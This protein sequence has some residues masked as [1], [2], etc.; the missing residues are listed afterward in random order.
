MRRGA[1]IVLLVVLSI[2]LLGSLSFVGQ[3]HPIPAVQALPIPDGKLIFVDDDFTDDP[4]NHKWNTITEALDDATHGDIIFVFEGIYQENIFVSHSIQLLG[5]NKDT[6]VIDGMGALYAVNILANNVIMRNFSVTNG[7]EAGIFVSNGYH[8]VTIEK[9]KISGDQIPR[10]YGIEIIANDITIE[11]CTITNVHTGIYLKG[12]RNI[13]SE[14][15]I[16][17]GTTQVDWG[18]IVDESDNCTINELI[19]SDIENKSIVIQNSENITI[20]NSDITNSFTGIWIRMSYDTVVENNQIHD[21]NVGIRLDDAAKNNI[22]NCNIFDNFGCGV[23]SEN[24]Y[25]NIIHHNNFISNGINGYD[26]GLNL[27]NTSIGNYWDDYTGSDS[28]SDGIGDSPY[29][30]G[31]MDYRP[32]VNV[33]SIPPSY[34]W[35][36]DDFSSSTPGWQHDQFDSIQAAV[37]NVTSGGHIYVY[38]GLYF[39]EIVIGKPISIIGQNDSQV[40]A[41]GDAIQILTSDVLIEGLSIQAFENG[42]KILDANN[43]SIT[44]CNIGYDALLLGVLPP[45]AIF[46]VY[47]VNSFDCSIINCTITDS[48]KGIYLFNTSYSTLHQNYIHNNSYFGI[49][50]SHTSSNN[51]ISDCHI[52]NNE[53]FGIYI[54]NQ[55]DDNRIWHNNLIG[56][57]SYDAA[58]NIWGSYR[59]WAV[60]N[61]WSGYTDNDSN[62]DGMGD[63]PINIEGGA[64]ESYP[65][66]NPITSPPQFV[67]VNKI[68]DETFPGWNIDHFVAINDSLQNVTPNGGCYIFP[69]V[70]TEQIRINQPV[71][72]AGDLADEVIVDG[73][74]KTA[75]SLE[76]DDVVVKNL[77]VVNCWNG[78]G[79]HIISNNS[80]IFNLIIK[81]N[82]DGIVIEGNNISVREAKITNNSYSG[83]TANTAEM[84]NVSSNDFLFNNQGVI[85]S[86]VGKSSFTYNRIMNNSIN[87]LLMKSSSI[88]N[89]FHHNL[90]SHENC[91]FRIKSSFNNTI[92]LN[93]FISNK[94]HSNDSSDNHWDNGSVGNY[95]DDFDGN[96][97]NHDGIGDVPYVVPGDSNFDNYPL[98]KR[99]GLPIAF[100]EYVPPYNITTNT[101]IN[102]SDYSVD[103]DGDIVMWI[104]DFDD[105]NMTINSLNNVTHR[106][107]DNGE[108][109]I[110]L[111][112][113]DDVANSD[114]ISRLVSVAN[115]P[116]LVNFSWYPLSP[117]GIDTI[118][119]IDNSS[120]SDGDLVNWT[121]S[122]GDGN[123]SY[124]SNV[125]HSYDTNGTYVIILTVTDDDGDYTSK[126]I[127]LEIINAPPIIAF[128]YS[129]LEPTTADNITFIDESVDTD[130]DIVNWTWSFGDGSTGYVSSPEHRY[131]DNGTYIVTLTITDNTNNSA[132][133]NINITVLNEPPYPEYTFSPS[134]PTTV[135][136]VTFTDQSID[137]DGTIISWFWEFGD[138]KNSTNPNPTHIFP[139]HGTFLVNLTIIDDDGAENT[140]RK[141]IIIRNT[142]PDADFNYLPKNPTDIDEISFYDESVDL[143][144]TVESFFW[145]FGDGNTS[146]QRNPV[147]LYD[148]NGVYTVR[149]TVTDNDGDTDA[150]S[151]AITIHNVPP[152]VNFSYTP[153]VPT[154]RDLISFIATASDVDGILVNF[155]WDFGDGNHSYGMGSNHSFADNGVY[156]VTF[157]AT[158]DDNDYTSHTL[159][160]LVTNIPPQALFDYNPQNPEEDKLVSFTDLSFDQDG[161][162]LNVT[163]DFGDGTVEENGVIITHGYN[164]SGNYLVTLTITDDDGATVTTS[165]TIEVDSSDETAG[166]EFVILLGAVSIITFMW[167]SKRGIWRRRH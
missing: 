73:A 29:S 74:G 116:P 55:S 166:F 64:T 101:T 69:G 40:I 162:I 52:A 113:T 31:V 95:W 41:N 106:F 79:V 148:T 150:K 72:I 126:N 137:I 27:W 16:I 46:A 14:T 107:A 81:N 121:W 84:L 152:I 110:T 8:D 93:D 88:D 161:T 130:G 98:I 134:N 26:T 117:T 87:G 60:G 71:T 133:A 7:Q 165:Q 42:L 141:D 63:V 80:T 18:I 70:Y 25:S 85:L 23:Y 45:K 122:F 156:N 37:D 129:P 99:V 78:A 120:D 89:V 24:S 11:N 128:E 138:G 65:L 100:F 75:F 77:T 158:D 61:F 103:L 2:L 10:L 35:V 159:A 34:V 28:D 147:H 21:N 49:E 86:N 154:D 17:G 1:G 56:N 153:V 19:S 102:F 131:I 143:D 160:I 142:P 111:T 112:V 50:L 135:N 167:F 30:V 51:I 115:M 96:D 43:V 48:Y 22:F 104:W 119:F 124:G 105:G 36:D 38:T 62:G 83:L 53:Q 3:F 20:K 109:N 132:S 146:N 4:P 91:G 145:T 118:T 59:S 114:S 82:Y 68:Y 33:I 144:G 13:I 54:L 108:Y 139:Q 5:E 66:I 140:V 164:K 123:V 9:C 127:S 32:L 58:D 57:P 76:V 15:T 12:S 125:T 94:C 90:F 136:I 155:S 97:S 67:W 44:D 92:Y 157:K 39:E 163:W 47:L 151:T 149:L 6:V